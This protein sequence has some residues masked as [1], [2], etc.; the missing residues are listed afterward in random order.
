M[1]SLKRALDSC[2]QF[3]YRVFF[4]FVSDDELGFR[5]YCYFLRSNRMHD[6]ALSLPFLLLYIIRDCLGTFRTLNGSII[7]NGFCSLDGFEN[8]PR[9]LSHYIYLSLF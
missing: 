5:R 6:V 2:F 9:S 7:P 3:L 8:V 4:S 1:A